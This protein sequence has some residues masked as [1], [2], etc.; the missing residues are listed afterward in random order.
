[1][2]YGHVCILFGGPE[3]TIQVGLGK[4]IKFEMHHYCGPLP[5][6][7]LGPNHK[8]WTAV[9]LWSQQGERVDDKGQCIWDHAA[10]QE[11]P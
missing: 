6:R 10:T 8:F 11:K 4:P 7:Q 1:M 3:Y 9:T 5:T 2:K